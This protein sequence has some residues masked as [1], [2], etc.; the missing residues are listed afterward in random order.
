M[1]SR[2]AGRLPFVVAV[3]LSVSWTLSASAQP[4]GQLSD[5]P[6]PADLVF[7]E[8]IDVRVVNVEV[9]VEDRAGNRAE[10]LSAD[11]FRIL[12]DGE[13]VGVDYFAEILENRAVDREDGEAPP[14]IGDGELVPTNY[15]LFVDDN[16]TFGSSRRPV[17]RGFA[18]QLGGLALRD[19]V[20]VVVRSG[21]GL[22][23]LSPFTADR[24]QTRE[25]L[26]ELEDGRRFKGSLFWSQ[27]TDPLRL[28]RDAPAGRPAGSVT[29]RDI[30]E[31]GHR[32]PR[33]A[34]RR[35]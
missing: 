3:I 24:E 4:A 26:E 22:E 1:R 6:P 21:P 30:A 34:L 16:H 5:P 35:I 13:D 28:G 27:R 2:N 7:G 25:A 12:V 33:R 11:D 10:G 31:D 9:V 14:A 19:Q 17:L 20:A 15:L 8:E 23:V 29:Q 18:T 32:V